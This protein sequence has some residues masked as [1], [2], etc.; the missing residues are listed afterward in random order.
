MKDK[1]YEETE[2]NAEILGPNKIKR[3][4]LFRSTGYFLT[5]EYISDGSTFLDIGGG[6]GSLSD[7]IS[8]EVAAIRPSIIDPDKK[9][10]N[11][12]QKT[13]PSFEFIHGYFPEGI[14]NGR[15][16][17]V[18]SMQALFPQMP[19]WKEMLL[20]IR[21]CAKKFINVSL[22]FKLSGTTVIDKDVSYFYYLDSGVRVHQ[23]IH[24]IYEFMNFLCISEMGLKKIE[25]Y[26]YHT[27]Y[28]GHNFRCVP[29]SEQIKGNIMLHCFEK[30]D[31][32]PKR[33]GGA[34]D[35]GKNMEGYTFFI[36]EMKI[37]IDDKE[38]SLRD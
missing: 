19:N 12:G 21:K 8:R 37:I 16:F 11:L 17:D 10:I 34:I 5:N 22:T 36:P 33:F 29:N 9:S 6:G 26:G 2:F 15:I 4:D 18:V 30:E 20:S 23:V 14:E 32:N 28:S 24:N 25:F 7:F 38:L 3:K 27:P 13:F 35:Y 1:L 31:E